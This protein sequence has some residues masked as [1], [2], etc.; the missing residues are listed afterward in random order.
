MPRRWR[1]A[2]G[3]LAQRKAEGHLN[4][5]ERIDYLVDPG[6]FVDPGA[7]RARFAPGSHKTPADGKVA[8]S[9]H[10]GA[11]GTIVSN[12]FTVLGAPRAA[13]ST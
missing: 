8:A 12:D 6:S 3:E 1:W 9:P 7:S 2:G 10:R 11:R 5:R 13:S 4:A